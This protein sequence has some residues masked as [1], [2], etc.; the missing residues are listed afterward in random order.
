MHDLRKENFVTQ[1]AFRAAQLCKADQGAV[2]SQRGKLDLVCKLLVSAGIIEEADSGGLRV[3]ERK[4][5]SKPDVGQQVSHG[6]GNNT[7]Y[8]EECLSRAEED[9]VRIEEASTAALED[10]R[11]AVSMASSLGVQ[12]DKKCQQVK[13]ECCNRLD[14]SLEGSGERIETNSSRISH[15]AAEVEGLAKAIKEGGAVATPPGIV[16]EAAGGVPSVELADLTKQRQTTT[17][18]SLPPKSALQRSPIERLRKRSAT[19]RREED[20]PEET[21]DKAR[22]SGSD[23]NSRPGVLGEP[24]PENYNHPDDARAACFATSVKHATS[25]RPSSRRHS[26]CGGR[27]VVFSQKQDAAARRMVV[28]PMRP[29]EDRSADDQAMSSSWARTSSWP[30]LGNEAAAAARQ[31]QD[32]RDAEQVS[33]DAEAAGRT[34]HRSDDRPQATPPTPAGPGVETMPGSPP[35]HLLAPAIG[36]QAE[37]LLASTRHTDDAAQ[38]YQQSEKSRRSEGSS[39]SLQAGE[40][41]NRSDH[42]QPPPSPQSLARMTANEAAEALQGVATPRLGRRVNTTAEEQNGTSRTTIAMAV[43]TGSPGA[44]LASLEDTP[45]LW[46]PRDT[47][48][49]AGEDELSSSAG[50]STVVAEGCRLKSRDTKST[51]E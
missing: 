50:S 23:P 15:L 36:D 42:R 1:G 31:L 26:A 35:L 4:E 10:A 24:F 47:W 28:G 9:I 8:L 5:E 22:R 44:L 39:G 21:H 6:S 11:R 2:K 18:T 49:D 40:S 37:E 19:T 20:D 45:D 48:D 16:R 34:T 30:L 12:V 17:T 41:M 3:C 13:K 33:V 7:V 27:R 46:C 38:K 51:P 14:E 32:L 29:Q 25:P 43:S